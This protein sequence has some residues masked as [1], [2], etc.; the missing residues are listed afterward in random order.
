MFHVPALK[1]VSYVYDK[2]QIHVTIR[3]ATENQM[4]PQMVSS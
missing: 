3:K 1:N 2:P 4:Q